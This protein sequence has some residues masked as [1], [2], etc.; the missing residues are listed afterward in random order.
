[1]EDIFAQ[2][3][4]DLLKAQYKVSEAIQQHLPRGTIREDYLRDIVLKRKEFLHGKKGIVAKNTMQGGECDLIFYG[5]SA[6]INPPGD[7]IIIEPKYCKLVLE[8]KSNTTGADLKKTN[9]NFEIVKSIDLNNQPPCGLF[10]YNTTLKKETILN[11]F[12]WAYDKDLDGWQEDIKLLIHYP[13]IDFIVC[14]A[15]LE[16]DEECIDKQFFLIKDDVSKRYILR[17][18][19]PIIKNFFGVTDNL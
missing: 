8:V 4:E 5:P 3:Y 1:M 12:G 17:Q 10:C 14:I 18:E 6:T 13:N 19:Y 9:K 2:Y 16:E 15:C 7:Q 11:R